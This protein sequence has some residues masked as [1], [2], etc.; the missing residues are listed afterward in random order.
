MHRYHG[1]TKLI[2]CDQWVSSCYI[3]LRPSI[4]QV[5]PANTIAGT[6][7][8]CYGV[9]LCDREWMQKRFFSFKIFLTFGESTKMISKLFP[10]AERYKMSHYKFPFKARFHASATK[11]QINVAL[12]YVSLALFVI[13]WTHKLLPHHSV[14]LSNSSCKSSCLYVI[15]LNFSDKILLKLDTIS[16]VV[17][18][19]G[20]D[21]ESLI[22]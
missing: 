22:V 12:K 18:W 11:W 16:N 14:Y 19:K 1:M 8:I 2:T 3:V 6:F 10:F 15:H 4:I 13:S 7:A 9:E 21:H 5:K 17:N 20:R